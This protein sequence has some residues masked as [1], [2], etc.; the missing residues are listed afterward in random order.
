MIE[1]ELDEP[2]NTLTVM[3]VAFLATPYLVPPTV[4]ATWVPWPFVSVK[5]PPTAL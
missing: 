2:E 3:S 5:A 1:V 4:P